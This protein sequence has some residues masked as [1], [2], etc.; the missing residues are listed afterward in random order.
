MTHSPFGLGL[1][2]AHQV[3]EQSR[4]DFAGALQPVGGEAALHEGVEFV[5]VA[6]EGMAFVFDDG[7]GARREFAGVAGEEVGVGVVV[8]EDV[9]G[10]NAA[11][12]VANAD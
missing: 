4:G 5:F 7:E 6:A 9:G 8:V 1:H 3:V 12:G 10:A 2:P 11:L